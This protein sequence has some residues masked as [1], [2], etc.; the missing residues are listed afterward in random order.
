MS[1][2][3]A[4]FYIG[5]V[6]RQCYGSGQTPYGKVVLMAST[7]GDNKQWAS[8]TPSGRFEMTIHS[9]AM[10]LFNAAIGKDVDILITIPDDDD[11]APAFE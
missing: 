3:R 7:R 9:D 10:T 4:K 8:A 2:V 11:P 6:T 5:E 1:Q